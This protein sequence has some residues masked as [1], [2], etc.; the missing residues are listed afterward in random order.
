MIAQETQINAIF[1]DGQFLTPGFRKPY[2]WDR[3]NHDGGILVY[4]QDNIPPKEVTT[5]D[6]EGNTVA[7][8][9]ESNS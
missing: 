3:N 5:F 8:F 7:I 2:R 4:V 6:I 9:V 1:Q